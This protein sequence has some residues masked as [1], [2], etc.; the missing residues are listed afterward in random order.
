[1][2]QVRG[3]QQSDIPVSG[4]Y[5][6]INPKAYFKKGY[7]AKDRYL[8]MRGTDKL[9]VML[10]LQ[11]SNHYPSAIFIN[12]S[13]C[14]ILMNFW[15]AP[16]L[17]SNCC[18][19]HAICGGILY[20]QH[21]G[22]YHCLYLFTL[23]LSQNTEYSPGSADQLW[24]GKWVRWTVPTHYRIGAPAPG[25]KC[26]ACPQCHW[27]LPHIWVRSKNTVLWWDGIWWL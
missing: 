5:K 7:M 16:H 13:V 4:T 26:T 18:L 19:C 3:A 14:Y 12:T 15:D 1:M 2:R 11:H 17:V 24:L 25:Y 8:C 20:W 21:P 27:P 23:D 10:N 6:S 22:A 9:N